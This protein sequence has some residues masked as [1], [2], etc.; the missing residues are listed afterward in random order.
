ML[1]WPTDHF[2]TILPQ[3]GKQSLWSFNHGGRLYWARC[4]RSMQVPNIAIFVKVGWLGDWLGGNAR[5]LWPNGWMDHVH[6]RH[7]GWGD[8]RNIVLDVTPIAPKTAWSLR[9]F[10]SL[11]VQRSKME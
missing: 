8:G 1:G 2:Y 3:T 11:R 6:F 10:T 9:E 4:I 7:T 5:A